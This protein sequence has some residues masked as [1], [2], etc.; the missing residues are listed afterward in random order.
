MKIKKIEYTPITQEDVIEYRNLIQN[1]QGNFFT[2]NDVNMDKR[3][4]T[5]RINEELTLVNPVLKE[6]PQDLLVYFERDGRKPNKVRKTVRAKRFVV[7]TDNLGDVEFSST[8]DTWNSID[9]LMS[10][11]GLLECVMA[12]RLM[13]AID[14][15]D[16]S[17]PKRLYN[18]S[19]RSEKKYGRNDRVM[20]Q[21]PNG[22][23]QFV[24]F[25]NAQTWLNQGYSIL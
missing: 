19:A 12:Q 9:E 20:L 10:D 3:I 24:K 11:E 5:I 17:D 8:L 15:I 4:I 18:G 2:A 13:D 21:G 16:V 1:L 7:E 25:K 6:T 22:E 14:G 23:M